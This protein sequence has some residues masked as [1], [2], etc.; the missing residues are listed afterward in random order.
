MKVAK[1]RGKTPANGIFTVSAVTATT[2]TLQSSAGNGAFSGDGMVWKVTPAA[3][4]GYVYQAGNNGGSLQLYW[5]N[6][7]TLPA[8]IAYLGGQRAVDPTFSSVGLSM[9]NYA[10]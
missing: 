3:A 4:T 10:L 7:D 9:D 6:P 8:T 2:F 5:I 1:V